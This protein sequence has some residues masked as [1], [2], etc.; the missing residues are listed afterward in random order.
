MSQEEKEN[1]TKT[2]YVLAQV[3]PIHMQQWVIIVQIQNYGAT[4]TD[5]SVNN[6]YIF[7]QTDDRVAM[8]SET[9]VIQNE[10]KKFS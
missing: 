7:K 5:N 6:T 1:A 9:T 8:R 3:E 4:M 10:I 2:A